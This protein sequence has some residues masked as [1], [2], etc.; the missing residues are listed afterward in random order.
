MLKN[1]ITSKRKELRRMKRSI[2]NN[3]R[4]KFDFPDNHSISKHVDPIMELTQNIGSL[5]IEKDYT[6]H[7]GT[8][9]RL[10][11]IM[12]DP[13]LAQVYSSTNSEINSVSS[14][15]R[16]S[17]PDSLYGTI[18]AIHSILHRLYEILPSVDHCD[19]LV[20]YYWFYLDSIW[21]GIDYEPFTTI[22]KNISTIIT[23]DNEI[24]RYRFK[25]SDSQFEDSELISLSTFLL[26]LR[27]GYLTIPMDDKENTISSCLKPL[28]VDNVSIGPE[29]MILSQNLLSFINPTK[30]GYFMT[31]LQLLQYF[32][33]LRFYYLYAPEDGDGVD[34]EE[35][36]IMFGRTTRL[37]IEMGINRDPDTYDPTGKIFDEYFKYKWRKAWCFVVSIDAFQAS[38]LGRPLLLNKNYMDT[39]QIQKLHIPDL[40]FYKNIPTSSSFNIKKLQN[41]ADMLN[42]LFDQTTYMT[43]GVN[44]WMNLKEKPR[45]SS[46]ENIITNILHTLKNRFP[47]LSDLFNKSSKTPRKTESKIEINVNDINK[48]IENDD[49]N[50]KVLLNTQ[51]IQQLQ[52]GCI[53]LAQLHVHYYLLFLNSD[54]K[55]EPNISQHYLLQTEIAA[56]LLFYFSLGFYNLTCT[57]HHASDNDYGFGMGTE[58]RNIVI[59]Q[60]VIRLYRLVPF[61]IS[62]IL[63]SQTKEFQSQLTLCNLFKSSPYTSSI[64]VISDIFND[65]KTNR[66][67]TTIYSFLPSEVSECLK[68]PLIDYFQ[69]YYELLL[70]YPERFTRKANNIYTAWNKMKSIYN[71]NDNKSSGI[72]I[73]DIPI[74]FNSE[75][76]CGNNDI[77]LDIMNDYKSPSEYSNNI[78][79]IDTNYD[80]NSYNPSKDLDS[81]ATGNQSSSID[82]LMDISMLPDLYHND[83]FFESIHYDSIINDT[84]G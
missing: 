32:I 7:F 76:A 72:V 25:T 1:Q 55:T 14:Y 79:H 48:L 8:T 64:M 37:A 70:Q 78:S 3:K 80:F 75:C 69:E 47:R 6:S 2:N 12:R 4:T 31:N 29:F 33:C 52:L 22:L 10:G 74:P 54:L 9:S 65:T 61:I 59:P 38:N 24:K 41:S 28:I 23:D 43:D 13:V 46:I 11:I 36:A 45:R 62:I 30:T 49:F 58:T 73:N 57:N 68:R 21:N 84:L 35:S 81:F 5:N 26:I 71:K 16:K 40:S 42:Y 27:L 20:K 53:L 77:H 15:K 56:C 18:V 82:E 44:I 50:M 34:G 17:E 63:R 67:S 66:G 19:I 83:L 51:R 39:K 60:M